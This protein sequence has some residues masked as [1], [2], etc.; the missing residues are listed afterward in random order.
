MGPRSEIRYL[1]S[2]TLR[3]SD[4]IVYYVIILSELLWCS[5]ISACP[6]PPPA[7][8][9]FNG[10]FMFHNRVGLRPTLSFQRWKADVV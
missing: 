3:N 6:H 1:A 7:A 8:Y 4:G 2:L 9:L 10:F 5:T